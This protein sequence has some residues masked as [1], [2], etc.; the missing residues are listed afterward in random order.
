MLPDELSE[1][2]EQLC[3]DFKNIF[4]HEPPANMTFAEIAEKIG[5]PFPSQEEMT[6]G[7]AQTMQSAGI[8]GQII[9]AYKKTGLIVTETNQHMISESDLAEWNQAIDEY[10][11]QR[12]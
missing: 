11:R 3:K 12:P 8:P 7:I 6:D 5:N 1:H 2:F 10:K 4:G 9:Y